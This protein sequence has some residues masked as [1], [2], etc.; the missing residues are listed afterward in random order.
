MRAIRSI[1]SSDVCILMLDAEQG[2]ESQDL[3]IFSLVEKNHKG[4]VI[5]VNKWDL[6]EKETNTHKE[7]EELIREKIAPFSDVPIIFVSV[8]EKQRIFKAMEM[9]IEVY[10]NRSRKISTSELNDYFLPIIDKTPPPAFKGKYIKIKYV[11]QLPTRYPSFV[12]FCNHPQYLK[13]PYQRF[14]ENK[15]RERFNFTGVPVEIYFRQ[16]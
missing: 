4:V 9:A 6:I 13:E 2:L 5:L 12:F 14:L 7:F 8:I 1:E 10:K 16:K 3:N 15:L 11:T